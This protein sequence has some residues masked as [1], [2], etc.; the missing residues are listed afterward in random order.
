MSDAA[1]TV[2]IDQRSLDRLRRTM[3]A[4]QK[5]LNEDI[6]KTVRKTTMKVLTSLRADAKIAPPKREVT[7]EGK[8][9]SLDDR[10]KSFDLDRTIQAW[11]AAHGTPDKRRGHL[12]TDRYIPRRLRGGWEWSAIKSRFDSERKLL[13]IPGATKKSEAKASNQAKIRN[14]KLARSS[15]TWIMGKLGGRDETPAHVEKLGMVAGREYT[16]RMSGTTQIT[17]FGVEFENKLKYIFGALQSG[18]GA[19]TMALVKARNALHAQ[20]VKDLKKLAKPA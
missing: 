18:R 14:R 19:V 8:A 12:P 20:T 11:Y 2:S 3:Q 16:G 15:F 10:K 17:R 6:R 9:I 1:L 5:V 4:R 7:E 13:P